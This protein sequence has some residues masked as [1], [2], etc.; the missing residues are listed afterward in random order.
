MLDKY[1]IIILNWLVLLLLY[2]PVQAQADRYIYSDSNEKIAKRIDEFFLNNP[3]ANNIIWM[4][5]IRGLSR[6][7]FSI[8]KEAY[9]IS[10]KYKDTN[11]LFYLSKQ[12]DNG[13]ELHATRIKKFNF[14]ISEEDM[15]FEYSQNIFS[16]IDVNVF[17]Q[18]AEKAPIGII[19]GKYF[20]ISNYKLGKII[21]EKSSGE[22][23]I[24]KVKFVNLL[25]D[26]RSELYANIFHKLQSDDINFKLGYKLFEISNR[27][28]FTV[29]LQQENDQISSELYINFLSRNAKYQI[30]FNKIKDISNVNLFFEVKLENIFKRKNLYTNL[31]LRSKNNFNKDDIISL[32][33][34]RKQNLDFVWRNGIDLN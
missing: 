10:K 3:D 11:D 7:S 15:R 17:I 20:K 21:A 27:Y 34:I 31:E 1:V 26:E 9:K 2:S 30:G 24:L 32:K 13:L 12:K 4:P 18:S 33:D 19:A 29:G 5:K 22:Y 25:Q 28:D 23:P 6:F 8:P 16:N 14:L